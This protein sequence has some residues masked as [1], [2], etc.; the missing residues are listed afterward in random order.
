MLSARNL[1]DLRQAVGLLQGVLERAKKEDPNAV[2][3]DQ[4]G[5]SNGDDPDEDPHRAGEA[6]TAPSFEG[7]EAARALQSILDGLT[8][9]GV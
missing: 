9:I 5:G 7:A 6:G 1:D 8:K 2:G 3:N 4:H